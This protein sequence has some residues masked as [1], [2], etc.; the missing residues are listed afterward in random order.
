[1]GRRVDYDKDV[2][3][4]QVEQMDLRARELK[5]VIRTTQRHIQEYLIAISRFS[6]EVEE[7][8]IAVH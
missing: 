6:P 1:L 4:K 2:F 5:E 3:M 8:S 7:S